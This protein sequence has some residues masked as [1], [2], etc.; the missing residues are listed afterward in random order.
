MALIVAIVVAVV[1]TPIAARIATHLGVVDHPGPLKVHARP[2]PYL[3]GV[4]VFAGLAGPVAVT[5]PSL[6]VPLGLA[7]ALRIAD[8]ATGLTPAVRL[9][10]E[11][12]IGVAAA[13]VVAPH[14]VGYVALG[15]LLVLVLANAVNMLDGLDGLAT[16]VVAAGAAGFDVVLSGAGAGA[17]LALAL[18]GALLGFLVWNAPPARV[19]L[20]DAGTYLMG[21][22]LAMLFLAAS[23]YEAAVVSSAFLFVGVPVADAAVAIVRRARAGTPLLRGDRGHVYDQLVDRGWSAKA[24]A[25]ACVAAQLVLTG[26]GIG[27]STLAGS[28]AIAVVATVVVVVG[29]VAIV[30]FTKPGAWT[31]EA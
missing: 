21:T 11:I 28:A 13:W 14:D 26:V 1:A 27:V 7:C 16:A 5:R 17:T 31:P 10:V 19:Y 8:D 23:R 6:L 12:G 22:A 30:T 15:I 24:A 9:V 4:A 3:G 20:G 18:A 25:A 2:V 29:A